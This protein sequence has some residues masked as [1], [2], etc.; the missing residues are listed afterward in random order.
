MGRLFGTDGIRGVA[1]RELTPELA[2]ALGRAAGHSLGGPG[3][4]VIIGRDT[5]RSGRMLESALAAGLC[6]VGMEAWLA[7]IIPTPGLAFLAALPDYVAGAVISASHNPALD[8]GIKFFDHRGLKLP[9][10]LEDTIERAMLAPA[11][12]A[13]AGTSR[14]SDGLPRPEEAGIG[15]VGDRRD[16]VERYVGWLAEHAPALAGMR[17]AIDCANGAT[18]RVGPAVYRRTGADLRVLF[19]EPNGVNINA[20]CGSTQPAALQSA[21]V[22]SNARVGFAFDG[23]GDRVV[24]VDERGRL[25]DGDTVL[26]ILALDMLRRGELAGDLGDNVVVGTVMTN[27]GL[28]ATLRAAGVTLA[29]TQVGDKYVW[30]E[31]V[32]RGAVLG[33]ESS[34]HIILR[35]LSSAGDGLLTSL[36]LLAV[37]RERG[38]P[39]SEL[40][41]A[42]ESWPQ[43]HRN[44]RAPARSRWREVDAFSRAVGE[45]ESALDGSGR[46]VVRP[47]GTEPV[48]RIL[49][50]GRDRAAC[51]G[52]ADR[53]AKAAEEHLV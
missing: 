48:L 12:S 38:A 23:D 36:R 43:V 6:S 25:V 24:A 15:R 53:L 2:L 40:A 5:R 44:V 39:L 8:N 50:E 19:A 9:D 22:E 1:N 31:L 17:V 35:G 10:Q 3:H 21:V 41:S 34:G 20:A 29:R 13:S 33:G 32:R 51:E 18:F 27:G 49:V 37:M 16:L 46:L 26:G 11:E 45:A 52:L 30:E 4:A 7:G 47:S 42:I 14:A 28:E